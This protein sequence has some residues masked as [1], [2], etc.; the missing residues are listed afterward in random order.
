MRGDIA[1]VIASINACRLR[2]DNIAHERNVAALHR[3]KDV[4]IAA[5]TGHRRRC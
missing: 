5:V 3:V 2:Q 1:R 4:G